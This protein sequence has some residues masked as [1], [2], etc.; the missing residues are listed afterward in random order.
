MSAK[1]MTVIAGAFA[2]AIGLAGFSIATGQPLA[3]KSA[4]EA[5]VAEPA[6]V[7]DVS[8][9]EANAMVKRT[10][11]VVVL[12]VRTPA[13]FAQGHIDGALNL[14]FRSPDFAQRLARLNPAGSYLLHCKTG[15]RSAQALAVMTQQGFGDIAHMRAGFDGWK[16]SGMAVAR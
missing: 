2:L 9:A 1:R 16:A 8:V 15:T 5:R 4:A 11:G 13:E 10:S 6:A 14:D 7:R 12:D 3:D